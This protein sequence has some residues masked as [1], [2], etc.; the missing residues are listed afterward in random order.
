MAI[1]LGGVLVPLVFRRSV[2]WRSGWVVL[3]WLI[4]L[5]LQ[6]LLIV[7]VALVVVK[8]TGVG[9]FAAVGMSVRQVS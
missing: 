7:A 6:G 8:Q 9:F 3:P 1:S 4:N 5:G 2:A